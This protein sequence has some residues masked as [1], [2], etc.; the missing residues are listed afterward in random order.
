MGE[1]DA[2]ADLRAAVRRLLAAARGSEPEVA[3]RRRDVEILL[4]AASARLAP[5]KPWLHPEQR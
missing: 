2:R 5:E 3:V 1:L 4:A